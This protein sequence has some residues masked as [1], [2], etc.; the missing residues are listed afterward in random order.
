MRN[1][2]WQVI[3]TDRKSAESEP[4]RPNWAV[5]SISEP[6]QPEAA[7]QPGWHSVLRLEFHDV[8]AWEYRDESVIR[9]SEEDAAKIID[10]VEV[11]PND[12]KGILV[13]CRAGIS[14]SAAVAKWVSEAHG[15]PFAPDYDCHNHTV[16]AMLEKVAEGKTM[17]EVKMIYA[18]HQFSLCK[19]M[20]FSYRIDPERKIVEAEIIHVDSE[21]I[22]SFAIHCERDGIELIRDE[23]KQDW[24]RPA[25]T[26]ILHVFG[27]RFDCE[28]VR[29]FDKRMSVVL[30]EMR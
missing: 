8:E 11:L 27:K 12:L 18:K 2:N 9:F 14:R 25:Y 26:L 7:L 1:T 16:L 4:A 10:F 19:D 21:L 17:D 29:L 13:H 24:H 6:P 22:A 30:K 3:F 15:L 23:V 20:M 5:I 28:V